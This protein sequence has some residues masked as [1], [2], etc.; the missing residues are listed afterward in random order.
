[1][2]LVSDIEASRA[3][4]A[5]TELQMKQMERQEQAANQLLDTSAF[6]HSRQANTADGLL[7][8]HEMQRK[9]GPR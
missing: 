7:A 6:L 9:Q 2:R 4:Q 5:A 8:T 3:A 1:M